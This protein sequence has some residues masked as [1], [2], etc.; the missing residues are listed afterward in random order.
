[1]R[2]TTRTGARWKVSTLLVVAGAALGACGGATTA[3]TSTTTTTKPPVTTTTGVVTTST[4]PPVVQ[5]TLFFTRGTSLGVAH[6][7]VTSPS[8]PRYIAVQAILAGPSGTESGAGLSTA[9]PAGTAL[10]GLDVK[11]GVAVVSLSQQFA[12]PGP[13]AELS[14]RLA[15]IVYTLTNFPNVSKVTIQIGKIQLVSFA[16]VDLT[17]PVGRAQVTAA[18]PP[19]LLVSPAVGDSERGS[20]VVSGLTSVAGIYELSLADSQGHLLTAVTNTAV[21]GGAFTQTIPLKVAS[22]QIGTLSLFAKPTSAAVPAQA[23]SFPLAIGPT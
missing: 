7:T 10:R 11:S 8:D 5:E 2:S 13:S 6:R 17:N 1:M 14:A 16:G 3:L 21:S 15:Q 23:I 4:V 22:S 9:M 20:L 12:L 19:V 18:L